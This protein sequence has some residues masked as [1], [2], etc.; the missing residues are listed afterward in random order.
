ME[1][2]PTL[3]WTAIR[4]I[5][6][7]TIAGQSSLTAENKFRLIFENL[8]MITDTVDDLEHSVDLMLTKYETMMQ[9]P[10]TCDKWPFRENLLQILTFSWLFE[11]VTGESGFE[12]KI[13]RCVKL[14]TDLYSTV[15]YAVEKS[16]TPL[17]KIAR[18][19]QERVQSWLGLLA[20]NGI[21]TTKYLRYESNQHPD[22]I[23]YQAWYQC[24]RRITLNFHEGEDGS[25]CV[26][27]ENVCDPQ[28][29]QLHP[30]Y[31]CE[32]GISREVCITQLHD[33]LV[34]ET[35]QP[36]QNVPG[37]WSGTLKPNPESL[38]AIRNSSRGKQY[39]DFLES[40]DYFWDES[41]GEWDRYWD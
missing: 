11:S 22:G 18:L 32:A 29:T 2:S 19:V 13:E 40:G 6:V 15:L 1:Y 3:E 30:E 5:E 17:D 8:L 10:A 33:V 14:T 35:G 36:K 34:D 28:Y 26:E 7:S 38:L 9:D 27:V 4:G 41:G 23:V 20:R 16:G 39:V 31:R 21:D 12:W 37:G 24:C 25:I